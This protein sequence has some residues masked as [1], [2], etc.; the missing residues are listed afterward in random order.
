MSE[1]NKRPLLGKTIIQGKLEC[2]TGLHIG[3]GKETMEIGDID[4]SVVRDPLTNR[5]YIPG[6]SIK[7]KIR[8]LTERNLGMH[9]ERFSGGK[10]YRHECGN[11]DCQLCR[12]YGASFE[13]N[14]TI[15]SRTIFRDLMLTKE[16]SEVLGEMDTGLE[17]TEWKFENT[18]DRVTSKADPRN[19][20][21]IPAGAVFDFEIIYDIV[22]P[23][24]V[25]DDLTTILNGMKLLIDDYLGGNGSRGYGKVSFKIEKIT[26]KKSEDYSKEIPIEIKDDWG[27]IASDVSSKIK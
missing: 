12:I 18:I 25:K 5:P 21:R 14:S 6:S 15:P 9:L 23:E 19:L 22:K 13:K 10:I 27:N 20:E 16:S 24:E 17:L 2:K 7:G 8:S 3:A 26:L 11:P 1:E 4:N